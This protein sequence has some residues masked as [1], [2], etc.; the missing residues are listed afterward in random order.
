[1][2]RREAYFVATKLPRVCEIPK[3]WEKGYCAVSS[4]NERGEFDV[5]PLHANFISLIR[6]KLII[7]QKG[8]TIKEIPLGAGVLA[9]RGN[10]VEVYIGILR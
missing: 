5:L 9:V 7:T 8:N 6:S 1:M 4:L 3:L 2:S 10:G